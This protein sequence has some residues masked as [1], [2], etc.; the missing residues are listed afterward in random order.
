MEAELL[1]DPI[2]LIR[3]NRNDKGRELHFKAR[4]LEEYKQNTLCT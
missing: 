4:K 2:I 1:P 3:E